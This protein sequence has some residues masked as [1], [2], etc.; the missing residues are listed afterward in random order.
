MNFV[1][2][3]IYIIIEYLNICY[4]FFYRMG[5]CSILILFLVLGIMW[6]F[7]FL[8]VNEYVIVF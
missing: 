8:F 2:V 5:I 1:S 4:Y 3:F 6:L 7:G